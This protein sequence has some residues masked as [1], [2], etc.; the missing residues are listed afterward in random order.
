MI[1]DLASEKDLHSYLWYHKNDKDYWDQAYLLLRGTANGLA[2]MHERHL[3]HGDVKT[4]NVLVNIGR[5]GLPEAKIA[6]FGASRIRVD[7]TAASSSFSGEVGGTWLYIPPEQLS[8]A[9]SQQP[10]RARQKSDVYAFAMIAYE[11]CT[12]GH[13]PYEGKVDPHNQQQLSDVGFTHD[14]PLSCP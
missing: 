4:A 5:T 10:M 13:E 11:A 8:A 7:V 6:D 3:I 1:C 14:E 2:A 12:R 9:N